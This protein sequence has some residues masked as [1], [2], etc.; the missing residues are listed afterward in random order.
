MPSLS[1]DEIIAKL[2]ECKGKNLP[3]GL[4]NTMNAVAAKAIEIMAHEA[5]NFMCHELDDKKHTEEQV[6]AI[7]DV[8]PESLSMQ[9]PDVFAIEG[10]LPI[11]DAA[12]RDESISFVPLLAKEGKRLNVY[13][14]GSRGGL[15]VGD[16]PVDYLL[17]NI[18]DNE[19]RVEDRKTREILEKLREMDL[20]QKKDIQ[21]FN[22]LRY[23]LQEQ[24]PLIFKM[25]V[26]WDPDSLRTSIG[27]GGLPIMNDGEMSEKTFEMLLKAGMKHFPDRLGFLFRKDSGKTACEDVFDQFGVDV[28]MPIISRCIPP[29]GNHAHLIIHKAAEVA[30]HLEDDL[31]RYYPNEVFKRD[32]TGRTLPLVRFHTALRNGSKTFKK[33]ASFFASATD[34]KIEA[35]DPR[36]GL[37]PFMMAASS[38][39]SDLDAVNYFLRRCPQVLVNVKKRGAG[40]DKLEDHQSGSRKRQR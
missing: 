15:V 11:D 16:D 38:N 40:E 34:D 10:V 14:E 12:T 24:N 6:Q 17:T 13:G 4:R 31:L 32:E 7:I 22:L 1:F 9:G 29:D 36:S 8:F 2:Q 30:P 28:A 5:T 39:R 21:N 26:D 35:K 25:L 3:Q 23:S 27:F 19:G 18:I 20:F 37:Y 33:A